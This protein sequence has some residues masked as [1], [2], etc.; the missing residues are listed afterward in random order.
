MRYQAA[1]ITGKLLFDY[2]LTTSRDITELCEYRQMLFTIKVLNDYLLNALFVYNPYVRFLLGTVN[3][4]RSFLQ[5][6]VRAFY[7][8]QPARCSY[9]TLSR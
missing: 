3:L 9:S 6:F 8:A 5:Q 1:L 7:K 4:S 2:A